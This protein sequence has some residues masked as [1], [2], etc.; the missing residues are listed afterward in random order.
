[1]DREGWDFRSDLSLNF[2]WPCGIRV[3]RNRA[4]INVIDTELSY[5]TTAAK[6][7]FYS[8]KSIA[9]R[10]ADPKL[11]IGPADHALSAQR[12]KCLI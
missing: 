7:C 1:M 5:S 6:Y 4:I 9:G 10:D 11:L 2:E 3:L 12:L 8:L